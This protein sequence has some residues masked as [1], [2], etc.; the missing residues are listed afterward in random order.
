MNN[1]VFG[2]TMENLR[3]RVDI[4]IVRSNEADKISAFGGQPV[5]REACD[6]FKRSRKNPHAQTQ[7]VAKQACLHRDYYSIE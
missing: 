1:S 3:N 7:A 2:K 5:I 4:N 6:I